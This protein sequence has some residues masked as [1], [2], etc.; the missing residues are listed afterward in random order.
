MLRPEPV[1]PPLRRPDRF[2][3]GVNLSGLAPS[4][5]IVL[6]QRRD[7]PLLPS[8]L[9]IRDQ[10]SRPSEPGNHRVALQSRRLRG[11]DG[12]IGGVGPVSE[13]VHEAVFF[14]I[15]MDIDHQ[16]TKVGVGRDQDA[17]ERPL[18]ERA[19]AAVTLVDGLGVGVEQ[20]RKNLAERAP[21]C[22]R[23]DRSL[24]SGK[25]CQ[26]RCSRF[27]L[28]RPDRSLRSGKTCQ[29]LSQV[30]FLSHANQEVKVVS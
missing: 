18:K 9:V 27:A 11:E 6:H 21:S 14:R 19:G 7:G 29:V 30:W 28:L 20:V 10:T 15:A 17:V 13:I 22:L 8:S 24:R 5:E 12:M 1:R 3:S 23:P 2:R 16:P 4:I 26:V 25:T